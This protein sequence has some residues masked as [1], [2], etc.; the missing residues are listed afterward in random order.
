MSK[1]ATTLFDF[2]KERLLVLDGLRFFAA[3]FVMIAHYVSTVVCD[4]GVNNTWTYVLGPVSGLG[5]PLFFVLSGFVIHYNY[6]HIKLKTNG[7]KEYI[8]ARITRIYPLYILLLAVEFYLCFKMWRGSC[9]YAGER[10]GLFAALPYYLTLTQD[11]FYGIIG[12]NSLIY[13]YFMMASVAWSISLE[14]FFY[15]CYI[16]LVPFLMRQTK[17]IRLTLIAIFAQMGVVLFFIYCYKNEALIDKAALVAFGNYAS[18][19]NG[20]QDSLI[21][22]LYYFNPIVNMPAFFLGNVVAHIFLIKKNEQL[23]KFE[24]SYGGWMTFLSILLACFAHN[25]FYLYLA[26]KNSFF[27]RTG[28]A[29]IVPLIA[30]MIFCLVR[31]S[32]TYCHRFFSRPFL[33]KLGEA[34]YSIYLLHAVFAFE[35]RK[36]YKWHL[37]PWLLFIL[38]LGCILLMSRISYL[39]FERPVQKWLRNYLLKSRRLTLSRSTNYATEPES[40]K[41][42]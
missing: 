27:G 35:W 26:Q 3:F 17:P 10:L 5:M 18:L 28:S 15:L 9:A 36:F 29:L 11:W 40:V 1:T 20:Y 7:V 41:V 2:S 37:N 38:A 12:T 13:Q 25:F 39:L 24:S 19:Q 34:S 42:L 4:Q 21:R 23:T 8:I 30:L 6:H 32:N 31:Y 16:F 14:A 33:V 22:W